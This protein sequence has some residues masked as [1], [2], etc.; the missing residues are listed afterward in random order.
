MH[1]HIPPPPYLPHA[2]QLKGSTELDMSDLYSVADAIELDVPSVPE[3]VAYLNDAGLL[4]QLWAALCDATCGNGNVDS[5]RNTLH[6]GEK[7][8][9]STQ[10]SIW[11]LTDLR[12]CLP[13]MH[14]VVHNLAL[15][16][17]L[18]RRP[19]EAGRVQVSVQWQRE[20]QH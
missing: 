2:L 19:A 16:C 13:G 10:R 18:C 14:V 9:V 5:L 4:G 3:F 15:L 7:A 12:Q 20:A 8:Q 1:A 6:R 11:P 17:L